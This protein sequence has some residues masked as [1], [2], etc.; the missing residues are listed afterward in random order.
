MTLNFSKHFLRNYDKAPAQ[1]RKA[2]DKQ[3]ALLLQDLHHPSPR[4]K[5]WHCGR[6]VAGTRQ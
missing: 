5:I 4:Q 6:R 3:F 1:I 2:F